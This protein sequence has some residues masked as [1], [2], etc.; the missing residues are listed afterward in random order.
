MGT[1]Q[2]TVFCS[3]TFK[4]HL[5]VVDDERRIPIDFE[6]WG[7]RS[8]L[9]FCILC[10]K[11]CGNDTDYNFSPITFKFLKFHMKV[12]HDE[13]RNPIDFASRGQRSRSNLAL[14]LRNFVGMLQTTVFA[15]SLSNITHNLWMMRLILHCMV[16]GQ[17]QLWHSMYKTLWAKYRLQFLFNH[18]QTSFVSCGWWEEDPYQFWV[19]GSKVK[20]NFCILCIKPCG[21]KQTTILVQSLSNFIWKLW[22]MRGGTLLIL[23]HRVKGQG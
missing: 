12:I 21:T 15:W 19:M 3:I 14:C 2:T 10:I 13:R 22:M 18:F 4:L 8:R 17:S 23:S 11:P 20:V 9:T 7:Q 6:S 1:V 5:L 16:N